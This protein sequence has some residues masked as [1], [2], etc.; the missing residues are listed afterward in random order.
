MSLKKKMFNKIEGINLMDEKKITDI[1]FSSFVELCTFVSF[2]LALLL[3]LINFVVVLMNL[4]DGREIVSNSFESITGFM[5][6][7]VDTL[8]IIFGYSLLG[9]LNGIVSFLPFKLLLRIKKGF[10]VKMRIE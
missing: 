10:K 3:V 1:Q 2:S 8:Y 9:F 4:L 5:S 7:I 6:I